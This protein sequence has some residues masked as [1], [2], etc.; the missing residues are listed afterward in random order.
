MTK[1]HQD[2]IR[3]LIAAQ[4][5]V[6]E[7]ADEDMGSHQAINAV[8]SCIKRAERLMKVLKKEDD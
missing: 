7:H 1:I 6:L 5:A 8:V 2:I 4:V 3:A